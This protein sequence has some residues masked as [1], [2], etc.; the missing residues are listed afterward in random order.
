L[1]GYVDHGARAV[2]RHKFGEAGQIGVLDRADQRCG[3]GDRRLEAVHHPARRRML[4]VELGPRR[5][6]QK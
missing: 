2:G 5:T 6:G 4:G 1:L 3:I